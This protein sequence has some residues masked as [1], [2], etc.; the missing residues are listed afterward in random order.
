MIYVIDRIRTL[1]GAIHER[2]SRRK[3]HRVSIK[4]VEVGLPLVMRY[5]DEKD[6][7]LI[8]SPVAAVASDWK[9]KKVLVI[10]TRD[11]VYTIMK[12]DD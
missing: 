1:N 12:E 7:V 9:S 3:G 5:I 4:N 6:T 11:T 10:Q 8:T 2:E